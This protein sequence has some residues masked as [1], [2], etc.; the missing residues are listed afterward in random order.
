MAFFEPQC[1]LSV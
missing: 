1:A